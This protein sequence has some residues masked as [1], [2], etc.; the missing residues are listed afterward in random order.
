MSEDTN[1]D[2]QFER[3]A[4]AKIRNWQKAKGDAALDEFREV[5]PLGRGELRILPPDLCR[6]N[7][8]FLF[9]SNERND[10][11]TESAIELKDLTEQGVLS[12]CEEICSFSGRESVWLYMSNAPALQLELGVRMLSAATLLQI[13]RYDRDDIWVMAPNRE[14]GFRLGQYEGVFDGIMRYG[15]TVWG[16]AVSVAG[17][18]AAHAERLP[19]H[20][21]SS[22]N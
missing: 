1:G 3:M 17:G 12:V 19:E 16:S 5:V 11:L 13:L 14:D 21:P 18:V 20:P 10:A 6:E 9:G 2:E 8:H 15:L 7:Q 22:D 4:I